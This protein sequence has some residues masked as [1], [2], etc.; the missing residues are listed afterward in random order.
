MSFAKMM[1]TQH[2]NNLTQILSM[3]NNPNALAIALSN[4]SA[5]GLLSQ[6]NEGLTT[7]GALQGSLFDQAYVNA[8]VTGHKDALNLI[9][10]KLMKTASSAEMKQFLTSTRAVVVQH[11]EH[12]QALQQKIGS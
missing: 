8:M 2:S 12:A 7:L 3:A 6:G 4:G 9:D 5:N 11:L 1:I 10:T